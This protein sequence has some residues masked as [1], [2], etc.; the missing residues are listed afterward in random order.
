MLV[1]CPATRPAQLR[2]GTRALA[3]EAL[4]YLH[5]AGGLERREL[6][7]ERR[8]RQCELIANEPEIRPL[9]RG[10]QGDDRESGRRVNQ[11]VEPR[12]G[13]APTPARRDIMIRRRRRIN[14]GPQTIIATP[15]AAAAIVAGAGEPRARSANATPIVSPTMS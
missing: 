9:R 10:E 14:L 8:I 1:E 7:G 6:L 13:H 4:A 12:C 15:P 2:P 3:D 5:V 11:F